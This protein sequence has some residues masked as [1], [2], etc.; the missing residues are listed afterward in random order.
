[1]AFW[2]NLCLFGVIVTYLYG[3]YLAIGNTY[4]LSKAFVAFKVRNKYSMYAIAAVFSWLAYAASN[5][6]LALAV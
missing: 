4:I 1:M 6:I 3:S 2:L 5:R